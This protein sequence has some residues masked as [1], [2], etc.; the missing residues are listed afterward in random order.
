MADDVSVAADID[1]STIA[2][3]V[4]RIVDAAVEQQVVVAAE[5]YARRRAVGHFAVGDNV[6]VAKQLDAGNIGPVGVHDFGGVRRVAGVHAVQR[7][8]AGARARN[9]S[10]QHIDAL[11]IHIRSIVQVNRRFPRFYLNRLARGVPIEVQLALR[12]VVIPFILTVQRAVY[13]EQVIGVPLGRGVLHIRQAQRG[14]CDGAARVV[15]H[16]SG[17][18]GPSAARI[19]PQGRPLEEIIAKRFQR[20]VC[21]CGVASAFHLGEALVEFACLR[22]R[23]TGVKSHVA[24]HK[25]LVL[26]DQRQHGVCHIDLAVVL[27]EPGHL[28]GPAYDNRLAVI[29]LERDGGAL[30]AGTRLQRFV[31]CAAAHNAGVARL[32]RCRRLAQGFPGRAGRTIIRIA[33]RGR[34]II[35]LPARLSRVCRRCKAEHPNGKH[36]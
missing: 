34:N 6:V 12:L 19:H 29:S 27:F 33:S 1:T 25:H 8:V 21:D 10:P 14:K 9:G 26:V 13:I 30:H 4:I 20:R 18:A 15:L 24:V 3:D 31:I 5:P 36:G 17:L 28:I 7:D 32:H 16:R 11:N 2:A 22:V 23:P 35:C